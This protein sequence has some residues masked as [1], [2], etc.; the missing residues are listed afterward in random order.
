M[1]RPD[2][3]FFFQFPE[4]GQQQNIAGILGVEEAGIEISMNGFQ[5]TVVNSEPEGV[6]H[7]DCQS[8]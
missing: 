1:D 3:L 4:N 2:L 8:L 5:S 6:P 7:G